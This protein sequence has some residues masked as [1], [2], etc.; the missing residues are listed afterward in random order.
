MS[1]TEMAASDSARRSSNCTP[2]TYQ[3]AGPADQKIEDLETS[4]VGAQ[5]CCAPFTGAPNLKCLYQ[6]L[7]DD[8]GFAATVNV[9]LAAPIFSK[10]SYARTASVC[11]PAASAGSPRT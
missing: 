11:S 5:H 10:R 1:L 2:R 7:R 4:V 3:S 6:A 8:Q 9:I